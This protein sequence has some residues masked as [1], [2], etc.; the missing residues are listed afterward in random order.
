LLK[1][2]SKY[3]VVLLVMAIILMACA[4]I[5]FSST[6][7]VID[8][9]V[10]NGTA[11]GGNVS[12]VNVLLITYGNGTLV[13]IRIAQ[14]GDRGEFQFSGVET[15]AGY[16]YLISAHYKG[17]DYYGPVFLEAN[18]TSTYT[19]VPVCETTNSAKDIRVMQ[20]H[21][22]IFVGAESL[23]VSE[24]FMFSNDGDRTYTGAEETATDEGNGTLAFTLPEGATGF[25]APEDLIQD[26]VFLG[27]RTFADTL[28]F[29]PS[30]R[31]WNYSYS[32][33]APGAESSTI[34]FRMNYPTDAFD[35]VV[36]GED[37]DVASER[38]AL[39]EPLES[40]TGEL[41]IHLK[42]EDIP[43]GTELDVT[44]RRLSGGIEFVTI[45]LWVIAG[46]LVV[47]IAFYLYKLRGA[48]R[49]FKVDIERQ[50][51]QLL[52]DIAELDD[53][54]ERG[55]I[56]E[57][58]YRQRRSEMRSLLLELMSRGKG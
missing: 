4:G 27:N 29:P 9:R 18:E 36:M 54:F 49:G 10:V 6:D 39:L 25:E 22:V 50:R 45:A 16:E 31:E 51:Q 46:L 2:I 3:V 35:V 12:G 52:R 24:Y 14:A 47:V 33:P 1:E 56:D 41:L 19:E 5:A 28:P 58:M 42:G 7:G 32:L 48:K 40:E 34:L 11:G 23:T 13:N 44:L 17:V 38:L 57:D 53:E 30:E 20:A 15:G 55:A 26:C 37:V 21:A 8:G 43:A